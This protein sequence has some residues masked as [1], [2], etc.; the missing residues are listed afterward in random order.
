MNVAEVE[1]NHADVN[2]VFPQKLI[3]LGRGER[4]NT[5]V[6]LVGLIIVILTVIAKSY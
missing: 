4:M 5:W 3:Q 2:V 1:L 6:M